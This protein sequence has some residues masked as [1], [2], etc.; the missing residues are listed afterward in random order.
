MSQCW[1]FNVLAI[2]RWFWAGLNLDMFLCLQIPS[3]SLLVMLHL[4]YNILISINL[5]T[6][7]GDYLQIWLW[8]VLGSLVVLSFKPIVK[9]LLVSFQHF[10]FYIHPFHIKWLLYESNDKA[11]TFLGNCWFWQLLFV[12]VYNC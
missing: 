1:S 8:W 9:H 4:F 6:W 10:L 7:L 11:I 2:D 3:S 12:C 5:F